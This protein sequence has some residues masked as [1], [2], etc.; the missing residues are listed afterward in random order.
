MSE[1]IDHSIVSEILPLDASRQYLQ[2][3]E[4]ETFDDEVTVGEHTI[5]TALVNE[6]RRLLQTDGPIIKP[7]ITSGN[8]TL[9]R[10]INCTDYTRVELALCSSIGKVGFAMFSANHA[11]TIAPSDKEP[12]F[13]LIDG[14]SGP[15]AKLN[16]AL[17]TVTNTDEVIKIKEIIANIGSNKGAYVY[18]DLVNKNWRYDFFD[19]DNIREASPFKKQGSGIG[20]TIEHSAIVIVTSQLA[21]N[22]LHAIDTLALLW[23][24]KMG[25]SSFNDEFDRANAILKPFYP[26]LS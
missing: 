25:D 12:E 1:F 2:N 6:S 9:N 8:T 26:K 13:W 22:M 20:S 17:S 21:H 18:W 3:I 14:Y 7:S 10:S 5:F 23:K 4:D 16:E 11:S 19:T 15:K 24:R